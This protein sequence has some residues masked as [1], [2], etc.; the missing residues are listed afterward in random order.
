[1]TDEIVGGTVSV[2]VTVLMQGWLM[3]PEL[4][5]ATQL[6]GVCPIG[7]VAELPAAAVGVQTITLNS[8]V[9]R[10]LSE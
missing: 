7:R 4:S 5:V 3:L 2:T 6:S 10:S 9:V 8:A 1:M